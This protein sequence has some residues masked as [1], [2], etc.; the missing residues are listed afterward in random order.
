MDTSLASE[1][2]VLAQALDRL[3]EHSRRSRDFT[4]LS[5]R[6]ALVEIIACLPVYRTYV[7]A[8]GWTADDREVIARSI[9]RARARNRSMEASIFDFIREVLLPRRDGDAD[10]ADP[11]VFGPVDEAEYG[12]RLHFS[13]RLQQYTAPVQ[14]KGVEDTAFYRH[15][16]LVS[17]NEVGGDADR[18]GRGVAEFHAACRRRQDRW[19]YAMLTTATHDTKLGEDTRARIDVLS[20]LADDVARR[21]LA[22]GADQRGQPRH[23]R[24]PAGAGSQR[25]IPLLPGA[26]G[27]V[28]RGVGRRSRAAR[29]R[30]R[31]STGCANTWRRRPRKPKLHTSWMAGQ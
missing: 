9:A 15:N 11:Y 1:L 20:E 30:P 27:R 29:A 4:L 23:H 26:G 5:L 24:W 22:L 3:A 16:V 7:S 8:D 12:R 6:D 18:F 10:A 2:T 28:A 19:P 31:W 13:K 21:S 14:A 17:L 25:R